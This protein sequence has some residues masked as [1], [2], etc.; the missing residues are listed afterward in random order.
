MTFPYLSDFNEVMLMQGSAIR[1]LAACTVLAV[2]LTSPAAALPPSPTPW[3]SDDFDADHAA[4]WVVNEGPTD[5]HADFFFD[6]S[7]VGIPPAPHSVGGTTRGLKLQT[8]LL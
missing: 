4:D 2:H 6:Y 7:T 3:F 5:N 8:N 1:R